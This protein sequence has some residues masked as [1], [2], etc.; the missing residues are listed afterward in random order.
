MGRSIYFC[1]Q[2]GVR[3][4]LWGRYISSGEIVPFTMYVH[5]EM[6]YLNIFVCATSHIFRFKSD[7]TVILSPI[8]LIVLL[9]KYFHFFFPK[10]ETSNSFNKYKNSNLKYRKPQCLACG[11]GF[12]QKGIEFHKKHQYQ[13]KIHI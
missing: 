5:F 2:R 4:G 8:N 12:E 10:N 9:S 1:F 7:E 3:R 6:Q 13:Q 11:W